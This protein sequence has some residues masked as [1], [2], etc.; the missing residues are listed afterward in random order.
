MDR[1]TV[2]TIKRLFACSGNRCAFPLCNLPLV[3]E[4]GKV[5][6]RLCHITARSPGGPRFDGGQ[7]EDERNGFENLLLLC[8]VHHDVVDA[9]STSGTYTVENLLEIKAT[10]EER[11][12]GG[13][14]ANESTANQLVQ[15]MDSLGFGG[16]S[17]PDQ[18][19]V[20]GQAISE[21]LMSL[22]RDLLPVG[23]Q[24]ATHILRERLSAIESDEAET[25]GAW[26]DLRSA[27]R[28]GKRS[29]RD[30]EG[31]GDL[32]ESL[33]AIELSRDRE[34]RAQKAS[35]L[36]R[37]LLDTK[38]HGEHGLWSTTPEMIAHLVTGIKE[39]TW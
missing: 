39:G 2:A 19:S 24:R 13:P 37:A 36:R 3:H 35:R 28:D 10:H 18:L 21:D 29:R 12:A 32:L 5:T 7:S 9:A 15:L 27:V 6:G 23:L 38:L 33:T 8:P 16:S 14:E 22:S 30:K 20:W 25:D 11:H 4:S 31:L 26:A 1:P 17:L 34:L